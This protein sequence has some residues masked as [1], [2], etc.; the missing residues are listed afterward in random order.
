MSTPKIAV[1]IMTD[2]RD[3]LLARTVRSFAEQVFGNIVEIWVMVDGDGARWRVAEVVYRSMGLRR[4]YMVHERVIGNGQRNGFGGAIRYA[5]EHLATYSEADYVFHLE[6]DFT[7]NRQVDL[8][9]MA[10]VLIHNPH[11]AQMALR[12]QAWNEA[13]RAAG[14]VIEQHPDDYVDCS[15]VA[16]STRSGELAIRVDWLEHTRFFTTNP[17]MYARRTA[18]LPGQPATFDAWPAGPNSEGHYGILLREAGYRFGFWG[19][20][21]DAPWVHHIGDERAGNGY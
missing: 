17:C 8:D 19:R 10:K 3:H 14:G 20:R 21:E 5:W 15:A 6:D 16:V 11:L 2:S 9:A 18:A 7:F 12:R 13:E 4:A 1:L